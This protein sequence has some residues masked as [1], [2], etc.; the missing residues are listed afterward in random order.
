MK[1]Y[2][3]RGYIECGFVEINNKTKRW[4]LANIYRPPSQSEGYFCQEFG[5][6]LDHFNTKFESF[7]LMGDFNMDDKGQN[8]SNLMESYS[9]K[10]I[11]KAPTCLTD[12]QQLIKSSPT[13]LLIF[14][15]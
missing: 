1:A 13:E 12:V 15:I 11:F 8:M 3:L 6:V 4:L 7:I 2:Q 5:K 9:L 10:T 14:K